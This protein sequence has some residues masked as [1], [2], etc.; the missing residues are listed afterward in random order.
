MPVE[1]YPEIYMSW[2]LECLT[3]IKE[4]A[5]VVTFVHIA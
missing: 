1:C 4:A 3:R 5:L 2:T